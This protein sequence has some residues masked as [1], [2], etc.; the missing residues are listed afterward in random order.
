LR[1]RLEPLSQLEGLLEVEL[2]EEWAV[3][4]PPSAASRGFAQ[5]GKTRTIQVDS[6]A[7]AK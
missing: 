2:G 1:R 3:S 6:I 7:A 5:A 4:P